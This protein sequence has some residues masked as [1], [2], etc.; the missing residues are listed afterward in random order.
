MGLSTSELKPW[1][2]EKLRGVQNCLFPSFTPDLSELDEEGIRW[3]VQQSIKHGFFSSVCTTESGLTFDEARRF[4]QIVV[5]EAAGKLL[6]STVAMFDTLQKNIAF[7]QHAEKVG[8]DMA[9]IG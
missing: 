4:V 1:A 2:W 3:D 6:V 5:E 9:L 8:C 7:L